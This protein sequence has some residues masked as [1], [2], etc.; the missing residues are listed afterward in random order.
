MTDAVRALHPTA[1]TLIKLGSI[2]RH[3][4]ELFGP[5]GHALDRAAIEGLLSDPEVRE[6]MAAADALALLPVAR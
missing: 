5:G 4:E 1:S 3:V 2:A 6:W